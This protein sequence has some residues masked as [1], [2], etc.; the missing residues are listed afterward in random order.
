VLVTARLVREYYYPGCERYS[1]D[2]I[3]IPAIRDLIDRRPNALPEDLF[4]ELVTPSKTS[5][6]SPGLMSRYVIASHTAELKFSRTPSGGHIEVDVFSGRR[7]L[8]FEKISAMAAFFASTSKKV[9]S[10]KLN[11]LLFYSDFVNYF[12]YGRSISGARYIRQL[13]GPVLEHFDSILKTLELTGVVRVKAKS[14]AGR[15][16]KAVNEPILDNFALLELITM[17]WVHANFHNMT[18]TEV[19]EDSQLAAVY[20][21]TPQDELIAYEYSRLLKKL[22]EL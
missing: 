3:L 9:C 6:G 16:Y 21:F 14:G 19:S 4:E 12:S 20:S 1:P 11:Q 2:W 22:P 7:R 13:G 17:Y 18:A 5:I 15:E 10:T 8:S